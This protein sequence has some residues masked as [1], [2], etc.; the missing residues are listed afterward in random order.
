LR[1]GTLQGVARTQSQIAVDAGDGRWF[2]LNASPDLRAQ[3]EATPELH[4]R[5]APRGTP[6]E[7][8][9]LTNADLDHVLG[10]LLMREF[11]P[12]RLYST[13]AVRRIL[14]EDNSVFGMLR[15]FPEQ[16]AWTDILPGH[17][18][19]LTTQR[20]EGTGLRGEPVTAARSYPAYVTAERRAALA[21][22]EA[23]LGLILTS[24]AG[25]RL[26]YF[27]GLPEVT[28]A[29]RARV[30][31]CDV[32][33]VDGTF[34]TDDELQRTRGGAG[35]TAR[36]MGHSPLSGLDGTIA[37]LASVTRPRKVFVHVNN[38]NPI[39]DE[40]SPE[41]RELRGAGWDVARDGMEI[42]L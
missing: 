21:D 24:P 27:P 2:L 11:Q 19:E 42:P 12:L 8:V 34:W 13:P 33:L 18:F 22:D 25:R 17:A 23:V 26:A 9:V 40:A 41:Y 3:I 38:T 16:L 5:T 29:W 36:Q 14:T 7:G 30:E 1:A 4:P 15:Q 6:I 32:L 39:L 37:R 10:L 28:D 20:G 31:D 35:K